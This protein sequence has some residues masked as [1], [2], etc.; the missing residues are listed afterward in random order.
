MTTLRWLLQ[1]WWVPLTV[2]G[3]VLVW[4]LTKGRQGK[5]PALALMQEL[6]AA[7]AA[8]DAKKLHAQVGYKQAVKQIEEAHAETLEAL[9]DKQRVQASQLKDDPAALSK[10]LIRAAK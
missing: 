3:A 1:H 6:D 4:V 7:N 2:A 9:D 5:S 8:A 10:F